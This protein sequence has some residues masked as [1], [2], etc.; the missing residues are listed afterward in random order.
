MAY[1]KSPSLF[2]LRDL[3]EVVCESL[4]FSAGSGPGRE[5][6]KHAFKSLNESAKPSQLVCLRTLHKHNKYSCIMKAC[7][8]NMSLGER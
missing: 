7:G 5:S 3:T 2:R 1:Q 6:P 4:D 8:S